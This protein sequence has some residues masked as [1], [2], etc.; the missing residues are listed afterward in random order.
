M[1]FEGTSKS[2]IWITDASGIEIIGNCLIVEWSII[3]TTIL[4]MD[5]VSAIQI[6]V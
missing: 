4:I 6:V 1:K 5:I 3:Q 2:G